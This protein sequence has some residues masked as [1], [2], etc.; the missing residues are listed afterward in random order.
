MDICSWGESYSTGARER[1]LDEPL[2]YN[3]IDGE[4]PLEITG[5]V[6][7]ANRSPDEQSR[8][9]QVLTDQMS[10][11]VSR[12]ALTVDSVFKSP[13]V[14]HLITRVDHG[15]KLQVVQR[16]G[17]CW[18]PHGTVNQEIRIHVEEVPG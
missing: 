5:A 14:G 11:I 2:L 12:E 7:T 1:W 10:A 8:G 9:V 17:R 15:R 4:D 13:Q 3:F 18:R 6:A 16:D